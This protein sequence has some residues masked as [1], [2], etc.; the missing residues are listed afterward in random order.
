MRYLIACLS[1][2]LLLPHVSSAG[3]SED[4][5]D[6]VY[7]QCLAKRGVNPADIPPEASAA[8]LT[9]AGVT[10][11]GDAVRKEKFEVWRNCLIDKAVEL[12]D[13]VSPVSDIARAIV[14]HCSSQWKE[15]V[16]SLAM[17]PRAKQA[18]LNG[19]DQYGVG[20]GVQAVLLVRKVVRE[21]HSGK[22]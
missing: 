1:L 11:L 19:I 16:G 8:C 9:E 22:Q 6:R 7:V 21:K 4:E 2:T 15:Y 18:M 13:G 20:H 5:Q 12:D 3:L 17:Y 10:D 14:P